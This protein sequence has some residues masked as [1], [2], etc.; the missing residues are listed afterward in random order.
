VKKVLNSK[1]IARLTKIALLVALVSFASLPF[2]APSVSALEHKQI[3]P[4]MCSQAASL[5]PSLS[6]MRNE[7]DTFIGQIRA[8]A[9]HEDEL[10]HVYSHLTHDIMG[11]LAIPHFWDADGGPNDPVKGLPEALE[12]SLERIYG[13]IPDEFPN[14]YQKASALFHYARVAYLVDNDKSMAYEYLGHVAHLIGDMIPAHVHED[15]HV[16]YE[17]VNLPGGDDCYEHWIYETNAYANWYVD[18]P[19]WLLSPVRGGLVK[20][21]ETVEQNMRNGDWAAAVYYLMY[22]ANQHA[23]YF[24]SDDYDGDKDDP[25]V[26]MGG[27]R[28][29]PSSPVYI[30]DLED[31]DHGYWGDTLDDDDNDRDFQLSEIAKYVM[32]YGIRAIATLYQIFYE[33]VNWPQVEVTISDYSGDDEAHWRW[34][35]LNLQYSV[36]AA[37]LASDLECRFRNENEAWH[38]NWETISNTKPWTLSAG[39][40]LKTVSCQVRNLMGLTN[41]DDDTIYLRQEG[42][43][44][45]FH[46]TLSGTGVAYYGAVVDF[47]VRYVKVKRTS[48]DG[49]V[50]LYIET[51][52]SDGRDGQGPEGHGNMYVPRHREP[53]PGSYYPLHPD[54]NYGW[55]DGVLAL[56]IPGG[57]DLW[58]SIPVTPGE[59]VRLH[60]RGRDDDYGPD[61]ALGHVWLGPF[62]VPTDPG[63]YTLAEGWYE[64]SD[65]G[66]NVLIV[67]T[68]A[69]DLTQ[70]SWGPHEAAVDYG[71]PPTHVETAPTD[72]FSQWQATIHDNS[73]INYAMI[74]TG[75]FF[76]SAQPN[77]PYFWC[78]LDGQPDMV[79]VVLGQEQLFMTDPDGQRIGMY[80]H[81]RRF[82]R[83]L[84][85][86]IEVDLMVTDIY[87][88][89]PGASFWNIDIDDDGVEDTVF[90]FDSRKGGTYTFQMSRTEE[91]TLTD[92]CSIAV[93]TRYR[94]HEPLQIWPTPAPRFSW[95]VKDTLVNAVPSAPI[96][97]VSSSFGVDL[98][99]NANAGG[100]YAATE[101]ATINFDASSSN[102]PNRDPIT[103]RWDFENDGTWDTDWSSSP[104]AS[105]MWLDDWTGTVKVEVGART[106]TDTATATA[107]VSNVAPTANAGPDQLVA[108]G[109]EVHFSGSFT[110]PGVVDTHT[111][112]WNFGDGTTATGTLTPTHAYSEAGKYTA[113][114]RITDNN[115]D[116]GT[117][118]LTINTGVEISIDPEAAFAF[119]G[120]TAT[121]NIVI[122]HLGNTEDTYNLAL[123]GINPA[124]C[125]MPHSVTL[126]P[127]QTE[128]VSFTISAPYTAAYGGYRFTLIATSQADPPVLGMADADLIVGSHI[129]P[130]SSMITSLREYVTS[131]YESGNINQ[132]KFERIMSDLG[133]TEINVGDILNYL[134]TVRPGF[135]DKVEGLNTLKSGVLRL[136]YLIKD[137][138][139]WVKYGQ[140]P[141]DLANQII[142][143]LTAINNEMT[144]IA[145]SEAYAEKM[146]AVAAIQDAEA[147]GKYAPWLWNEIAYID[148]YLAQADYWL[149]KGWLSKAVDYYKTTFYY[150]QCTVKSAW[151]WS[152]NISREDWIDQLEQNQ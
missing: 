117:D 115:G 74:D 19:S 132:Y 68:V 143:Q 124:W 49:D 112:E 83:T 113:T 16:S 95:L 25:E 98:P 50:E 148:Q 138:Q 23:D 100:P 26:W 125:S 94:K 53:G 92:R 8:G 67:A 63:T 119:L 46:Y 145:K 6:S 128:T 120:Q 24:A 103:Y 108:P 130:L 70:A 96:T 101:S 27:Y 64:N 17:G 36:G 121:Y 61:D 21:P 62:T 86:P 59:P 104:T 135:D 85:I 43:P 33:S 22:T 56:N 1:K 126:S 147:R 57:G 134:E 116:T 18:S 72:S 102:D 7:I 13:E 9:T 82:L 149:T 44:Q 31:N 11:V 106:Y 32:V 99:P 65:Y 54:E 48:G 152:W 39:D 66:I 2:Q 87:N 129:H 77:G 20:F 79:V 41:A 51:F 60:T 97:T 146:L 90:V 137:L 110:D 73:A 81:L 131:L 42:A 35:K 84:Q 88:E 69:L 38:D 89:I 10:D 91:A 12:Q 151:H 47:I 14:A 139:N 107:T 141:S 127:D 109:S 80:R 111:I 55:G 5:V 52:V 58:H 114:L 150:S 29:W 28:A 140:M 105:H 4:W 75:D 136:E 40:D 71:R 30:G 3:H 76:D 123:Y 144:Q 118:T 45:V 15:F 122:H 37:E 78:W 133:K 34:V 142:Q 93:L